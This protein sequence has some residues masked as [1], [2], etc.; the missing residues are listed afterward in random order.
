MINPDG[1]SVFISDLKHGEKHTAWQQT[2]LGHTFEIR[3]KVTDEVLKRVTVEHNAII[4]IGSPKS[5][6]MVRDVRTQVKNTFRAEWERAHRVQRTFTDLGFNRGKLPKDLWGS[7]SA[8]Y[9]NNRMNKV[10]EEWDSKG[11][12]VNWWE[13]DVYFIP[14]PWELKV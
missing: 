14:M 5:S 11:V 10:L 7:I 12:F 2:Y 6:L 1:T 3:D 13:T 9:Y 8:Y 4:P